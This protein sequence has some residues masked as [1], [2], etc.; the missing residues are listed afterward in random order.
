MSLAFDYLPGFTGTTAGFDSVAG[1]PGFGFRGTVGGWRE[2][3][4][5]FDFSSNPKHLVYQHRITQMSNKHI[6]HVNIKSLFAVYY[7]YYYVIILHYVCCNIIS[8]YRV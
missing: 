8:A 7:Y 3:G 2:R 1:M 4:T 5:G 6:K